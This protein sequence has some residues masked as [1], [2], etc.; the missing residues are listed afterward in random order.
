MR[1][2]L[3]VF[4]IVLVGCNKNAPETSLPDLVDGDSTNHSFATANSLR[5]NGKLDS[6]VVIYRQLFSDGPNRNEKSY[7]L[8]NAAICSWIDT[9]SI[10]LTMDSLNYLPGISELTNGIANLSESEKGLQYLYQA[11][12]LL[13]RQRLGESFHYLILLEMCGISHRTV[14]PRMDSALHYFKTAYNLTRGRKE[15]S[16]HTPRMLYHLADMSM[17][18]R[19]EAVGLA[20]LD[21]ALA[22]NCSQKLRG[23]LL[24]LRGTLL[25]KLY[26]YD[27]VASIYDAAARI[28][29]ENG[30]SRLLTKVYGERSVF[31]IVTHNDTLFQRTVLAIDNLP[32]HARS[33]DVNTDRLR[34]AYYYTKNDLVNSNKHYEKALEYFKGQRRPD[35]VQLMEC[36]YSLTDQYMTLGDFK[37]AEKYAYQ[38]LV[39]KTG[40][41]GREITW[42]DLK[43]PEI[44][45]EKYNFINYDLLASIFYRKFVLTGSRESLEKAHDLYQLIDSLMVKQVRLVDDDAILKSLQLQR[46]IYSRAVKV[47]Y[48]LYK[49]SSERK[50]LEAAHI[51]MERSKAFLLCKDVV[52]ARDEYF[53]DVPPD[54]KKEELQLKRKVAGLKAHKGLAS[55]ELSLALK[56]LEEFY[57][58]LQKN[59]QA[60]YDARYALQIPSYSEVQQFSKN[61]TV[62]IYQYFTTGDAIYL[63]T[64]SEPGEFREIPLTKPLK[65]SIEHFRRLVSS[66]PALPVERHVKAFVGNSNYVYSQLLAPA[67]RPGANTL[68]VPDQYIAGIPFEAMVTGTNGTFRSAGYLVEQ[69]RISYAYSLKKFQLRPL[70]TKSPQSIIAYSFNARGGKAVLPGT[71]REMDVISEIF[72][73]KAQLRSGS[74]TGRDQLLKDLEGDFDLIHLGLHA[75]SSQVDRFDNRI[76]LPSDE[77]VFGYEVVPLKIKATTVVLTGCETAAGSYLVGEGTFSL[78][79]CFQQA[80]VDYVVSSLWNL[81]DLT[82]SD[83]TKYFY[84]EL[85]Q[86]KSPAESI[87][88]AKL[89][90]LEGSDEITAHPYFWAGLVCFQ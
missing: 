41:T 26:R 75:S 56:E 49:Y 62:N 21:E 19:N 37:N 74:N 82:T 38:G 9:D 51:F 29:A 60:Y 61:E 57:E 85:A 28:F 31:A 40:L 79:R 67:F 3:L 16:G 48:D 23:E 6:A 27:S 64:Y 58:Q 22:Y 20:Y 89:K 44:T 84:K 54:I 10:P 77:Q 59:H 52:S 2:V 25:R 76:Y 42:A 24:M 83:V 33:A 11:R 88:S 81:P 18:D 4:M 70:T 35:L 39:Y 68:I 55:D 90:Y 47:S 80:G 12:H 34:G 65:D 66:V 36:F 15:L 13:D 86:G 7:A 43:R 87:S 73:D 8:L 46:E 78:G 1:L 30:M 14:S 71:G 53:R 17:I 63:T 32:E 5:N 45:D 69:T 50:Y 72:V